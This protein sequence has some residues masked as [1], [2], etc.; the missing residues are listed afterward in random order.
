MKNR[1]LFLLGITLIH[2]GGTGDLV[3][4]LIV[5][6]YAPP[7]IE[8]IKEKAKSHLQELKN[9]LKADDQKT[10]NSTKLSFC[11][12]TFYNSDGTTCLNTMPFYAD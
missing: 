4:D 5:Y 1:M 2:C 3:E 7:T 10:E 11:D 9:K 8:Q 6:T 12:H